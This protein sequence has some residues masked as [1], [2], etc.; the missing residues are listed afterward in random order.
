MFVI[1]ASMT[2]RASASRTSP[3]IAHIRR[4]ERR[5]VTVLG[6]VKVV[7]RNVLPLPRG[8]LLGGLSPPLRTALTRSDTAFETFSRTSGASSSGTHDDTDISLRRHV[9][10]KSHAKDI[11]KLYA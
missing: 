6:S 5:V 7:M 11:E 1:V 8:A 3:R 10:T 2:S 9:V 4:L